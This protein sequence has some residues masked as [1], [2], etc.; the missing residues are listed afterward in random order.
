MKDDVENMS[1]DKTNGPIVARP[2]GPEDL[3]ADD[4]VCVMHVL[5]EYLPFFLLMEDSWKEPKPVRLQWLPEDAGTPL[6][7]VEVC[8]PFVL[9]EQVDGSHRTLDLRRHKLA[10]V[11]GRFGNRAFKRLR[12]AAG[13]EG[14]G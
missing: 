2:L 1:K 4:Y 8:V 9:V 5:K 7:V 10:R 13:K 14:T 12:K 6:R 11:S 3:R